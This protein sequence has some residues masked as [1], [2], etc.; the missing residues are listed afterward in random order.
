MLNARF[1]VLKITILVVISNSYAASTGPYCDE[2]YPDTT[3]LRWV[4]GRNVDTGNIVLTYGGCD[5][6]T[7]GEHGGGEIV[8]VW[9]ENTCAYYNCDPD[10]SEN[11]FF[12]ANISVS[13]DATA[14]RQIFPHGINFSSSQCPSN[15]VDECSTNHLYFKEPGS[16][17]LP[18]ISSQS[19]RHKFI[20]IGCKA[21]KPSTSM[22]TKT[23]SIDVDYGLDGN[24]GFF[25]MNSCSGTVVAKL[26]KETAFS[27]FIVSPSIPSGSSGMA[28]IEQIVCD[29]S[30]TP[31]YVNYHEYTCND[32]S[33]EID[34]NCL[35][36]WQPIDP[37][38]TFMVKYPGWI[39][40]V[41][42]GNIDPP[43]YIS[44]RGWSA[45]TDNHVIILDMD[46]FGEIYFH[47]GHEIATGSGGTKYM[48][49]SISYDSDP[50][51]GESASSTTLWSTSVSS[52]G[53]LTCIYDST[54]IETSTRRYDYDWSSDGKE[55][56]IEYYNT[57]ID[58]VNPLRIWD[59]KYDDR[60]RLIESSQGG[61][62]SC[63]SEMDYKR[64]EYYD[65]SDYDENPVFEDLVN[66]EYNSNG[67][68]VLWNEYDINSPNGITD[69]NDS[70]FI[71]MPMP[72][73]YSQYAI[74]DPDG[75]PIT[76]KFIDASYDSDLLSSVESKWVDNNNK[77]IV[78]KYYSDDSF[79]NIYKKV[80][81]EIINDDPDDPVGETYTTTYSMY[82]TD[83]GGYMDVTTY[84]SGNRQVVNV[85]DENS[86][87]SESYIYDTQ[88]ETMAQ[89][90]F[91]EYTSD[92]LLEKHT[93][94]R[95]GVT[96]YSY[97]S[98]G[99]VSKIEEPQTATG[100]QQ[101][102]VYTYDDARRMVEEKHKDTNDDWVKT[103]YEYN[104]TTGFLDSII[105]DP[106]ENMEGEIYE[107]LNLTTEYKYND[108]GQVIREQNPSGVVTGKSYNIAGKL[109]SEFVL[110]DAT[111]IDNSDD[112]ISV[113]SQTKYTYD[114]DGNVKIKAVALDDEEFTLGS[115][116]EWTYT[117][118]V[119]DFLGRKIQSIQDAVV[120]AN[121]IAT[122]T[123]LAN[124]TSGRLHLI[125]SYE[126][127]N[128]GRLEKTTLP[129]GKW[130]KTVRDGRG[131]IK[132]QSVGYGSTTVA[133]TEF[134]YDA[135]GNMIKQKSPNGVVTIKEYDNFGRVRRVRRG[136]QDNE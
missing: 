90:E 122:G 100:N 109:E 31:W 66:K 19:S 99:N 105:V 93:N 7:G 6:K 121:D 20:L 67:D 51:P 126:Y 43:D 62:S 49:S 70:D 1:W 35:S 2:Y 44:L 32:C 10:C 29:V 102:T 17:F 106:N 86:Q 47:C 40:E 18:D 59:A 48:L 61:C 9:E 30:G 79:L 136:L 73:L 60:G 50:D 129:N 77:Q 74:E 41:S 111:D 68:I 117:G 54:T 123:V 65:P 39:L 8:T 80:E 131:Y 101:I 38:G 116:D 46:S 56:E 42:G 84:P 82:D 33:L 81:Y 119:Y 110:S 13:G 124:D 118:F 15:R 28:Y 24:Y 128:Q 36:V 112:G 92:G 75:S 76:T 113:I 55:L 134:E 96:A 78:K 71:T 34:S 27:P 103:S 107:G 108:F 85:W 132:S 11:Y 23:F 115:P 72:L 25:P 3:D 94:A 135:D 69:P 64:H 104:A 12:S 89:R 133:T 52:S 97:T 63:G 21:F 98:D 26:N 120:D 57:D 87:P 45:D 37:N 83:G 16:G 125:T 88:N 53:L 127:D 22:G 130:T 4:H 91:Y 114:T 14:F 58:P 95:G 5:C